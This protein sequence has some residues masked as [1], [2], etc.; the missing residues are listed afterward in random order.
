MAARLP[1]PG[2]DDG[3]WGNILNDFLAQAHNPDGTLQDGIVTDAKISASA[4]IPKSKL[5]SSVQTSLAAADTAVQSVN[6]KTPTSGA[7]TLTAA[8]VGAPAKPVAGADGKP[9]KWNNSTGQLEDATAA[10]NASYAALSGTNVWTGGNTF[11]SL[12]NPLRSTTYFGLGAGIGSAINPFFMNTIIN[13]S[14]SAGLG[15]PGSDYVAAQTDVM[16]KGGFSNLIYTATG[17]MTGS[18]VTLTSGTFPASLAAGWYVF[19]PGA[20]ASGTTL[21]TSVAS[22]T[23]NQHITTA[24]SA[25]IA[26]TGQTITVSLVADPTFLFGRDNYVQTGNTTGDLSGITDYYGG[27][28][29]AHM[30]T[31]GAALTNIKG[32]Q[33]QAD[34]GP[35]ATGATVTNIFALVAMQ[36]QNPAGAT[37]TNAYGLYASGT[38]TPGATN[39]WGLY[40]DNG[41]KSKLTGATTITAPNA[42][43]IPLLIVGPLG[44]NSQLLQIQDIT[45]TNTRFHVSNSG[46][47]GA[48]QGFVA[49]E[50]LAAQTSIGY[51][52]TGQ[53]S[54]TFGTAGDTRIYRPSA[55][56]AAVGGGLQIGTPASI[57]AS[58]SRLFSGSGAPNIAASIAGDIYFRTDTPTITNQRVYVATAANTW[59]GIL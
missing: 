47:V 45:Q 3:R 10:L 46:T 33:V 44:A 54:V 19:I 8:D 37:I 41:G 31:P 14:T 4:A 57:T 53:A 9:L 40:V 34:L 52:G 39:S 21:K 1:T 59:T 7:V 35:T 2:A 58:G 50:G 30:L 5:A 25:S 15:T 43:D 18:A 24:N 42:S 20:G 6:T 29:E 26:V 49:Y 32:L 12:S 17:N 23:D 13:G 38:P 56:I 28:D 36:P 51:S 48:Q 55:G 22:I 27:I 11:N 16:F